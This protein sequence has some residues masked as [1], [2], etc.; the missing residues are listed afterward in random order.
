MPDQ[1]RHLFAWIRVFGLSSIYIGEDFNRRKLSDTIAWSSVLGQ[2]EDIFTGLYCNLTNCGLPE[3]DPDAVEII[4]PDRAAQE[5]AWLGKSMQDCL[6]GPQ[7]ITVDRVL[8]ELECNRE[9]RPEVFC[10]DGPGGTG[11]TSIYSTIINILKGNRK[12]VISVAPTGIHSFSERWSS[13]NFRRF[14]RRKNSDC[15]FRGNPLKKQNKTMKH[16]I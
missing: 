1:L 7:R 2:L 10:I 8:Q 16:R 5:Y 11:K 15:F 13:S 12:K 3:T 4:I 14:S 9:L 6:D